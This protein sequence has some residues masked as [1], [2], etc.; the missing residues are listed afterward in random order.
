ML[1]IM[2]LTLSLGV[3]Q[4]LTWL[5]DHQNQDGSWGGDGLEALVTHE[6]LTTIRALAGENQ[7]FQDGLAWFNRYK[8]PNI[9]YESRKAS[10]TSGPTSGILEDQNGD[11]GFGFKKNYRSSILETALALRAIGYCP[12][13]S[14]A[15][16]YLLKYQG[17]NG[18]WGFSEPDQERIYTTVQV[19]LALK[20][21]EDDSLVKP[22]IQLGLN[23]LLSNQNPDSGFGIEG[24]TIYETGLAWEVLREYNVGKE[25]RDKAYGYLA[26]RQLP[27]GSWDDDPYLTAIALRAIGL[28]RLPDLVIDPDHLNISKDR[29]FE[30]DTIQLTANI[31]NLGDEG[32]DNILVRF[33]VDSLSIDFDTIPNIPANDSVEIST[34]WIAV[35]G[36]HRIGVDIDPFDSIPEMNEDNN[37]AYLEI[38]VEDTIPPDTAK[39]WVNNPI[40]SPN[41]DGVKDTA[42]LYIRISEPMRLTL[43]VTRAGSTLINLIEN[44]PVDSGLFSSPWDGSNLPDGEYL[45]QAILKSEGGKTE[46]LSAFVAID[47][48]LL[49]I[50]EGGRRGRTLTTGYPDSSLF[51]PIP[52]P[53]TDLIAWVKT[54]SVDLVKLVIT[55][56]NR[57]LIETLAVDTIPS[58]NYHWINWVSPDR[59]SYINQTGLMSIDLS[60]NKELIIPGNILEYRYSPDRNWISYLEHDSL[61]FP[62]LYLFHQNSGKK[63]EIVPGGGGLAFSENSKYLG[64]H[65]FIPGFSDIGTYCLKVGEE[66]PVKVDDQG[67]P[68]FWSEN[69]LYLVL[70]END[71]KVI[72]SYNPLT[73]EKSEVVE[74]PNAGWVTLASGRGELF[75]FISY[76]D[77]AKTG[78]YRIDLSEKRCYFLASTDYGGFTTNQDKGY[79]FF[80]KVGNC[81]MVDRAGEHKYLLADVLKE[82]GAYPH[83]PKLNFNEIALI[84]GVGNYGTGHIDNLDNLYLRIEGFSRKLPAPDV[85]RIKG[86]ATDRYFDH[87][88][89]EYRRLEEPSNWRLILESVF[90]ADSL[91]GLWLPPGEGNYLIRAKGRD[92]AG[93]NREDLDTLI[94]E[95]QSIIA[96]LKLDPEI[97][98]P[99]GRNDTIPDSCLIS[100]QLLYPQA[101]VIKITDDSYQLKRVFYQPETVPGEYSLVWDGRDRY[102]N[103]V[104]EG[105]YHILVDQAEAIAIVDTGPPVITELELETPPDQPSS[106]WFDW[107]WDYQTLLKKRSNVLFADYEVNA[108]IV[109]ATLTEYYIKYSRDDTNWFTIQHGFEGGSVGASFSGRAEDLVGEN[110]FKI[111]AYDYFRRE[112]KAKTLDTLLP[113]YV[114]AE[115]GEK[116]DRIYLRAAYNDL[117]AVEIYYKDT[118]GLW[119]SVGNPETIPGFSKTF[120]HQFLIPDYLDT[121]WLKT[122]IVRS[123]GERVDS[124]LVI[125]GISGGGGGIIL[126]ISS[127]PDSSLVWGEIEVAAEAGGFTPE[128]VEFYLRYDSLSYHLG[129]DTG[130]PFSTSWDTRSFPDGWY[131]LYP[132]TPDPP[133]GLKIVGAWVYINNNLP[134]VFLTSPKTYSWLKD[135]ITLK[136]EAYPAQ[137]SKTPISKVGFEFETQTGWVTIGED[138][139]PPYEIGFDTKTLFDGSHDFRAYAVDSVGRIGYS[140]VNTYHIDNTQP[141]SKIDHPVSG[142]QFENIDSVVVIGT[143][144]DSNLYY[145]D[146]IRLSYRKV[147][148]P[149]RVG[150]HTRDSSIISDTIGFW[151]IRDLEPGDYYLYLD[152]EDRPHHIAQDS[153]DVVIINDDPA[154]HVKIFSPD[155]GAWQYG[156]IPITGEVDDNNLEIWRLQYAVGSGWQEIIS[157]HSPVSGTLAFFNTQTVP[158]GLCSLRLWARDL[159]NRTSEDLIM[160]HVDNTLPVV[161]IYYPEDLAYLALPFPLLVEVDEPYPETSY[162]QLGR[163]HK[164]TVWTT[165]IGYPGIPPTDTGYIFDPLPGIGD[166]SI[167]FAVLD[168]AGNSSMDTVLIT[169]DTLPPARPEGLTATDS[170]PD[171]YLSWLKN[172]EPDLAGYYLYENGTRLND[173]VWPDTNYLRTVNQGGRYVY[174]VSAVDIT[175]LES[176]R[177]DSVVVIIDL[178]PPKVRIASPAGGR[179]S[180]K[181][182]IV[183][184]AY[185]EE[186]NFKEYI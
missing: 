161:E 97:F 170:G 79:L 66:E 72:N 46:I 5:Y 18:G 113:Y 98:S 15:V 42:R 119:Q 184:S 143:A 20:P 118:T 89:L 10:A 101:V 61:M 39:I 12:E 57:S 130:A 38:F 54:D 19:L 34:D 115:A 120:Y 36:F 63:T 70:D 180:G 53:H 114:A 108:K 2:T 156:E 26:R 28:G 175:D 81:W 93:N 16:A 44:E 71:Q 150:F 179:I 139:S 41:Q 185:D 60:G 109:D 117:E 138:P 86:R 49:Q 47:R 56:L 123:S 112:T 48:N 152:V 90:E 77:P 30:L 33:F 52:S 22:Q 27:N 149:D 165:V 140:K 83:S 102:G 160:F 58:E 178:E 67:V 134:R 106:V 85:V 141:V 171:I 100:Y 37:Q 78:L 154:P 87:Y 131:Y 136:A 69:I 105:R 145:S 32:G 24:S 167:R 73:G 177:S 159:N 176:V 96:D 125:R 50:I 23:F 147:G 80:T 4:G 135:S 43:N 133:P 82:L 168:S 164:P 148:S 169:I 94:W 45:F 183:G 59:I 64:Y 146:P 74:L 25:A 162:V 29:I 155:S 153:V 128:V 121:H 7:Y 182:E 157:G 31:R 68:P 124:G 173:S 126:R 8:P 99:T 3:N 95:W 158:D 91:L 111:Q 14:S 51:Y 76:P 55:D 186:D 92:K 103:I 62:H 174:Q 116:Q 129:S 13:G 65:V 172:E 166:F 163:S 127:P 1:L 88:R 137:G 107:R 122:R 21:Y 132:E 17:T 181:I 6:A 11:G 35:G 144:A 104:D 151:K 40:F 142:Q 9:D 84:F 110:Y 75:A